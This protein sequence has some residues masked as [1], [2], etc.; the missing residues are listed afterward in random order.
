MTEFSQDI[1]IS[2]TTQQSLSARKGLSL[3]T[4]IQ[5]SDGLGI[6]LDNLIREDD[7]SHSIYLLRKFLQN[8]DFYSKL[9]KENQKLLFYHITECMEIIANE[10]DTKQPE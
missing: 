10:I 8:L 2:R 3:Y 9:T 6:P 4:A 1:G 7:L 5:I